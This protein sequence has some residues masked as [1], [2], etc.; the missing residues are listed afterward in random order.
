MIRK[1]S[2]FGNSIVHIQCTIVE[3]QNRD[4]VK[5]LQKI[6][7]PPSSTRS[8]YIHHTDVY[9]IVITNCFVIE[10][11]NSYARFNCLGFSSKN[12]VST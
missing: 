1:F 10:L 3:Q 7:A 12:R 5:I 8:K 2:L 6:H 11:I 4:E 9:V